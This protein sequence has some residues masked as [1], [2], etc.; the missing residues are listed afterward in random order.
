MTGVQHKIVGTG[1]GIAGAYITTV[2]LGDPNGIV[3]LATAIAGSMLPDIDHDMTKIGRKRKVLTD[4]TTGMANL[5][6]YGGII[7]GSIAALLLIMGFVNFGIN[8]TMLIIGVVGLIAVAIMKKF[9][10][11]SK[12]FKWATRH[13]GL[14]HTLVVPAMILLLSGASSFPLY[15]YGLFGLFIGY[16]SHLFAD[17]LTVEGCPVL[18]P[19]TRKNI[20]F[21]THLRTKNKSCTFAA[22]IVCILAILA[23]FVITS[24]MK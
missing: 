14:M 10:G 9:I 22:Y 2:G 7:V 13:R 20:R 15:H 1:F 3:V 11:N 16:I 18:F 6:V 5:V 21:P 12:T 24:T 17:M 19:L 4:L 23:G 8:P